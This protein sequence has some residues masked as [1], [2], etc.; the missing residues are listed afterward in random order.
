MVILKDQMQTY[1]FHNGYYDE[2]KKVISSLSEGTIIVLAGCNFTA[3]AFTA[4]REL[5]NKYSFINSQDDEKNAILSEMKDTKIGTLLEVPNLSSYKEMVEWVN[6][7][8]SP[9]YYADSGL[10]Y[11]R[12]TQA[13]LLAIANRTE[14]EFDVSTRYTDITVFLEKHCSAML[15]KTQ[16][17]FT[18]GYCI[19]P[20]NDHSGIIG[21]IPAILGVKSI[22]LENPEEDNPLFEL[23]VAIKM[24]LV[25]YSKL[26]DNLRRELE[27]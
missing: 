26:T 12:Q 5:S 27:C 23:I 17:Y 14:L 11:S 20:D 2:L 21:R 8:Q 1:C 3:S 24:S 13:L 16:C 19:Y 18:D 9:M 6:S 22:S 10:Y 25:G 7:L 15:D 4:I